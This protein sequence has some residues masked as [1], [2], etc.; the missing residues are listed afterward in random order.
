MKTFCLS[1]LLLIFVIGTSKADTF[2]FVPDGR[3]LTIYV[4]EEPP[5]VVQCALTMFCDDYKCV[6]GDSPQRANRDKADIIVECSENG[7]WEHFDISVSRQGRLHVKGSDPRGTAYG[8]LELS[9]LI[10]I[11]PWV[12]WADVPPQKLSSYTL[13]AG[14]HN[15]QQPSVQYRGIFINDEDYGLNPWSW[16][17]HEPESDKGEIGPRTYERIFQLLLRLRAN[18]LMPAMHDCSVPFYMVEGNKEMAEKY[19]IVMATSHCEPLMRNNVGEWD[20]SRRGRYNYISNR[21]S[22]LADWRERLEEVGK[23]ENIYTIGMRG[24]H[25]GKMEG[26]KNTAEM[27]QIMP[28]VI[29]DQRSLLSLYVD[30][31]ANQV[32][33]IFVPYKEL[34]D[35]YNKGIDLPDDVTL[36][37]CDDNY[38]HITRLSN[39]E[40]RQRKGGAG[41][42][43]H[44]SYWGRPHS[45]LWLCTTAPAQIYYEMRR[46][47]DYGARKIWALNVGDIKPAEY[48]IEFFMDMA[49]NIDAIRPNNIYRH[50]HDFMSRTFTPQSAQELTDIMNEYYYLANIRRPEF[51]GWSREEEYS[52][53]KGGKTPVTDTE[54]SPEEIEQR[55]TA[56]QNLEKRVKS[57]KKQIPKELHDSFFQLV[58]YPVSGAANMNYKWL[59]AQKARHASTYAEALHYETASINA[60][61]AIA[62]LDRHYNF[63]MNKGKWNGIISMKNNR[64]VFEKF[65]LPENFSPLPPTKYAG[66]EKYISCDAADH[67]GKTPRGA[68]SIEGLGY[69]RRAIVLPAGKALSNQFETREK[70]EA[71][72]WVSLLPTHPVNGDDLRYEISVD[73]ETPQIVSFKTTGRSEQWKINVLR[74]LV[75]T[76]TRHILRDTHTHTIRLKALDEGVVIDQLMLDFEPEKP[77]YRIP[78]KQTEISQ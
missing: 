61:N 73:G 74:N 78:P 34:L 25:D 17:T 64:L 75:L 62:A 52:K 26:C 56:Y 36:M 4:D 48:D 35:V 30:S 22:V 7:E 40:E 24:K 27:A 28:R 67:N 33:Q 12:W 54:F 71:T 38:G 69:S 50:L 46:A 41:I 42:Y 21:D 76:S 19:Q 31:P 15:S 53:I 66:K 45:Y 65:E 70:G 18:M 43:Y 13:P 6:F 68:Y 29:E 11:S 2:T 1:S 55:I 20:D 23:S 63:D 10:G 9:R 3:P 58:E 47:W 16:K 39:K 37:W 49:W 5:S 72:I 8:I 59:Y 32:P 77:F 60:Y 44:I 51:M 57:I 14:Y